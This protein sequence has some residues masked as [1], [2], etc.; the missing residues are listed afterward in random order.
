MQDVEQE[1]GEEP[2]EEIFEIEE[3]K[4]IL[5]ERPKSQHIFEVMV[6]IFLCLIFSLLFWFFP[7]YH[8]FLWAS[9]HNV[10]QQHEYWR[11]FSALFTHSDI[12]H[13]LSNMPL[14]FVFGWLLRTYF[15]LLAFPL[16]ALV[17]GALANYATLYFYSDHTR[18]IGASG[19][20][21]GLVGLWVIFYLRYEVRF[22]LSNKLLRVVG[23][24]MLFL[25]PTSYS[26]STSYL[27]HGFGFLF[28]MLCA[29]LLIATGIYDRK[30][31]A[32][33]CKVGVG[34]WN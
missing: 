7:N 28:G 22:S 23:F 4:G 29:A 25:L 34:A 6:L 32:L 2:N 11:L 9:R 8:N 5:Y 13:L 19:I 31:Q 17:A 1:L 21:Y 24:S 12:K 20:D 26:A 3:P 15:G 18:L 16:C 10:F 33:Q 14:F 27:A 30:Q